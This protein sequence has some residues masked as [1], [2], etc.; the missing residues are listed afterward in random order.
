M[1][2]ATSLNH[3]YLR[4]AY[5]MMTSVLENNREEKTE[6]YLLN[7]DLTDEDRGNLH[8]LERQYN[9]AI[10]YLMID[11]SLFPEN[12]AIATENWT[13]ESYFRLMLTM[14][15]PKDVDRLLYLDVDIIVDKPL[16]DLYYQDFEEN[17]FCVCREITFQGTFSDYRKDIFNHMF[18]EEYQYFNAGVMLWNIEGLRREEYT[19]ESYL[20]L[21]QKVGTRLVAFDQDLLN[22]MHYKQIKYVDEYL[23]D[24]FPR[25]AYFHG[26]KYEDVKKETVII[27]YTGEKPWDGKPI[28]YDTEMLWWEYAKKTPFYSELMEEFIVSCL[29]S[30]YVYDIV[31]EQKEQ[32]Q[33]A[34]E[35]LHRLLPH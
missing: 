13:L 25:F 19:F 29:Q 28:H 26:I 34:S 15:L 16:T 24:L 9:C 18:S 27:H 20:A 10:H 2:I 8:E 11:K 7:A 6:F 32:L 31:Q 12:L 21:A 22:L 14:V 30:S 17:M 35:L 4:Y 1:N 3:K 5:V 33:K 23:Y